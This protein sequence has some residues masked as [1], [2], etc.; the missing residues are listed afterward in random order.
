MASFLDAKLNISGSGGKNAADM[1]TFI[2][3]G[4][5][6]PSTL[7]NAHANMRW[8]LEQNYPK[9]IFEYSSTTDEQ[10]AVEKI[11]RYIDLG[12]PV[13]MAVSHAKV[14]GH[15]VR[16]IGYQ[17]FQPKPVRDRLHLR[18]GTRLKVEV[19]EDAFSCSAE[20]E[21]MKLERRGQR[22]VITGWDG[23]DAAKAVQESREIYLDRLAHPKSK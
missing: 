21:P 7:H 13:L 5:G 14:A 4:P 17:N 1:K 20:D 22:R 9:F 11:V 8:R 12:Y 2:N 15:I 16:V 18:E 3:S 10:Q 23:F 19:G 6:R